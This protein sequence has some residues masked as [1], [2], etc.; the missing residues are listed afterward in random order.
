VLSTWIRIALPLGV[1][2]AL[3]A[4]LGAWMARVLEGRRAPLRRWLQPIERGILRL[5]GVP[6]GSEMGWRRYAACL[7]VFQ[8]VCVLAVYLLQRWQGE[9]P[10]NP[11]GTPG[12]PPWLAF[13]TAFSFVTNTNWQAY[14]GEVAMSH[15]TQMVGLGVQNFVSAAAGLAVLAAL[16]R[17]FVRRGS[18]TIG[19][20]WTDLVRGVVH[21]LLPLALLLSVVLVS[22]GVPQTFAADAQ[23]PLLEPT[24]G[25]GGSLIDT[26]TVPLGPVASQVAI[27][28]LGT[29]GGGFYGSNS[30]H[31]LENPT[32][33]S[34]LAELVAI[35]LLPAALC[36]SFGR[37]VGQPRQGWVLLGVMLVLFVPP[38]LLGIGAEQQGTPVLQRLGADLAP[39]EQQPGGNMEGKELRF[40]VV[41]SALWAAATTAASNGSVN[42]MHEAFTPLGGLVPLWFMQ[43]GEVVFGGVGSG[44]YGLLCFGVVA[45]FIAG[46]MV[47]RTP[48]WL[49]KKIGAF[50]MKMAC[51]AILLPVLAVLG[52]T[53]LSLLRDD[54]LAALGTRGPHGFSELLYAWSSAGN[55]NGS[56]FAGLSADTP[57]LDLGLALAMFVGRFGVMLPVLAL[58]G[59]LARRPHVPV[60]RG[61]LATDGWL[62]LVLLAT[63]VVCVGALS[64][65]P[66][67]VLG[68]I[69][70][71]LH[72]VG[73][74]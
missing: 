16:T 29:N 72:M 74:P 63:V 66:A 58:A 64:F 43:L 69:V 27:K 6:Q 20:F 4:P 2:V 68:P 55:N 70:E 39:S 8:A 28:Q 73:S 34:H 45:V 47:G 60:T 31:P 26:Q 18:E 67:L 24:V 61:T 19:C 56:A 32:P 65:V 21:V 15:F 46:L 37:L 35:L 71:H 52:G 9:L 3:A 51:L 49:G 10:L 36:L 1:V 23:V 25:A 12:V 54:V 42:S 33:A 13:N 14:S 57:F 44:L 7:L 59:A 48:E 22:Q 53:A 62:F 17:G 40:G 5:A 30:A 41:D 11:R 50:E 38:L